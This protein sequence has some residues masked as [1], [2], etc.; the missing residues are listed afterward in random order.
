[1]PAIDFRP[2]MHTD[3]RLVLIAIAVGALI[4]TA[5]FFSHRRE[6]SRLR[7]ALDAMP[8]S[9]AFFDQEDRLQ[10]WN[11]RYAALRDGLPLYR[12]Q[13]YAEILRQGMAA[14]RFIDVVDQ[15]AWIAERVRFAR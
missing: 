8:D 12:G 13:S 14:N 1:M 15:E 6:L 4:C 5:F 3:W 11:S 7:E 2:M 9:L 10:A